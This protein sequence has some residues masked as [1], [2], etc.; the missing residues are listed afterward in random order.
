VLIVRPEPL[1]LAAAARHDATAAI[2]VEGDGCAIVADI[3]TV[4]PEALVRLRTTAR[5]DG[6]LVLRDACDLR[7][8]A[9][10]VATLFAVCAD[11]VDRAA[12]AAMLEPIVATAPGVRGGL[13]AT[14]GA[15][16]VRATASRVWAAQRLVERCIAALRA[17]AACA[18][19]AAA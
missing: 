2:A 1:M 9:G 17:R 13:G 18:A 6:R 4:S 12:M 10:A 5:I 16:V 8:Q 7:A 11:G 15:I 14:A 3:V 19:N